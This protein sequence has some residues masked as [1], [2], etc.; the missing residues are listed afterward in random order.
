MKELVNEQR[1][2]MVRKMRLETNLELGIREHVDDLAVLPDVIK[3]LSLE[4]DHVGI[5]KGESG[6]GDDEAG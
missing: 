6:A 1:E 3:D 2:K 4:S 5:S